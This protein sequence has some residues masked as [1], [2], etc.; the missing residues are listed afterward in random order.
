MPLM[1]KRSRRIPKSRKLRRLSPLRFRSHR[2]LARYL[3]GVFK[4]RQEAGR[5]MSEQIDLLWIAARAFGP[6][7]KEQWESASAITG[8]LALA[9]VD[10]ARED[11]KQDRRFGLV[12]G[13]AFVTA[14]LW[15]V[16]PLPDLARP[17]FSGRSLGENLIG[18]G[19]QVVGFVLVFYALM[20]LRKVERSLRGLPALRRIADTLFYVVPFVAVLPDIAIRCGWM[21]KTVW[22][23]F[24]GL[25]DGAV[26]AGFVI[27]SI[28]I[29]IAVS[30]LRKLLRE[31]R[32]IWDNPRLA[33]LYETVC[34]LENAFPP[35]PPDNEPMRRVVHRM[36]EE[37]EGEWAHDPVLISNFLQLLP[38]E[39]ISD[40]QMAFKIAEERWW[41]FKKQINEQKSKNPLYSA[42]AEFLWTF[43]PIGLD[44]SDRWGDVHVM[45]DV[46]A[47]IRYAARCLQVFGQRQRTGEAIQDNWQRRVCEERAAFLRAL[48]RAALLPRVDT[49]QYLLTEF[50]R[51]FSLVLRNDWGNMPLI[52]LPDVPRLPWWQEGFHVVKTLVVAVLPLAALFAASTRLQ[53]LPA[54]LSGTVWI[55]AVIWL[56][57]SLLTLV[58]ERF[59]EKFSVTKALL[60]TIA[61]G[62][63]KE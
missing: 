5:V 51:M 13:V 4:R 57:V 63:A 18:H 45:S 40:R 15:L 49:R 55:G 22:N 33:F 52:E 34:A 35:P 28:V 54:T 56:A 3:K 50:K 48:Q 60:H 31:Q 19:L 41:L 27:M 42:L 59:S 39:L 58:D 9:P 10:Q 17:L 26:I 29:M 11:E 43:H 7:E 2:R 16:I 62:K 20:I 24:L 1:R 32:R 47:H 46:A 6:E 61:S 38:N 21:R 44:R 36:L 37:Y 14:V 8:A 25:Y 30:S 53:N 12:F 23:G